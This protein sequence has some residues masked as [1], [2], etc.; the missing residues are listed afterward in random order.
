MENYRQ[1]TR[2]QVSEVRK[3]IE[4]I[5]K[6]ADDVKRLNRKGKVSVE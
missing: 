5:K 1:T 4:E 3:E 2:E 6:L